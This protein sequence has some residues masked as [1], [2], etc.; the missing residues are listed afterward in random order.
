MKRQ[1]PSCSGLL[2][3]WKLLA[4]NEFICN[5]C[6]AACLRNVSLTRV[7]LT[8]AGVWL[9]AAGAASLIL[10][11]LWETKFSWLLIAVFVAYFVVLHASTPLVNKSSLSAPERYKR[12]AMVVALTVLTIVL[13]SLPRLVLNGVR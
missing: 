9:L 7:A 11:G 4:G 3:V 5:H 12:L 10:V 2:P 8:F 13:L 1:C 6:G